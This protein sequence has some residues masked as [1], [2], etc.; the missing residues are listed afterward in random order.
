MVSA[1]K[2]TKTLENDE[3]LLYAQ[4]ISSTRNLNVVSHEVLLRMP[5][6]RGQLIFP[7][8][9][10]EE[11]EHSGLMLEIDKWV[12]RKTARCLERFAPEKSVSINASKSTIMHGDVF[13]RYL[14]SIFAGM[15]LGPEQISVE[16]DEEV[17]IFHIDKSKRFMDAL[18]VAGCSAMID[19]FAGGLTSF[20]YLK[21]LQPGEVKIDGQ[22]IR[23]IYESR[24]DQVIVGSI[25]DMFHRLGKKV[26]AEFV[27]TRNA[28]QM[29]S[30]L[31][32][33]YAQG[34]FVGE[35]LP[36]EEALAT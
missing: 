31:G 30:A 18:E 24:E 23:N 25:I 10:L 12:A 36:L 16:V 1:R 2:I 9:F 8:M 7:K 21:S 35:T 29:V 3:F 13:P 28:H 11:A 26:T 20:Y 4:P 5:G 14:E 17:C 34:S 22:F 32:A 15:S 33:D 27:S 19:D 6:P